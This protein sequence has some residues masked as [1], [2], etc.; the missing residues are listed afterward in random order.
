MAGDDH[1][2][3][4]L[5]TWRFWAASTKTVTSA[6]TG[7]GQ[8]PDHFRGG[9]TTS[10]PAEIEEALGGHDAIGFAG[11]IASARMPTAGELPCVYVELV[12]GA[13]IHRGRSCWEYAKAHIHER[14]H[15]PSILETWTRCQ[16]NLP[17]QDL[18]AGILRKKGHSP[19]FMTKRS[20]TKRRR[21]CWKTADRRTKRLGLVAHIA[22]TATPRD[23][24]RFL[25]PL[26]PSLEPTRN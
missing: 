17:R 26:T 4:F 24:E 22:G 3:Q 25:S 19:A 5:R 11:A 23:F 16:K 21:P 12:S 13:K 6:I 7:R 15:T 9:Q 10:D 14:A 8:G 1:A 18:Q 20:R 2:A